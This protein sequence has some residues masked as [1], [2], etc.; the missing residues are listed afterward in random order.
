MRVVV[1]HGK[2]LDASIVPEDHGV[3]VP[4]H[5]ALQRWRPGDVVKKHGEQ[6]IAFVVAQTGD[7]RGERL[8]HEQQGTLGVG[9]SDHHR[10]GR[11]RIREARFGLESVP[12]EILQAVVASIESEE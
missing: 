3:Y 5:P 4:P 10:V 6:G 9:V 2:V 8:V 11:R 7:P 12:P 1:P